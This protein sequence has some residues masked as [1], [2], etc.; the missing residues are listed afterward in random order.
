M[1]CSIEELKDID[2]L[3]VDELQVSLLIHEQK[4]TEKKGEEQAFQVEY[5][6]RNARGRGRWNPQ[7][8][9]DWSRG[10]G[11]GRPYVNRSVINCF[12]C[13]KHGHYQFK[14]NSLEKEVNYAEFDNEEELLLMAHVDMSESE[15][16]VLWFLDSGCSNHMT[17]DKSWFVELDEGF[18]HYV[19]LGNDSRMVV[20]GK[21]K[22]RI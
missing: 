15:G 4:V 14:C 8:G 18:K 16:E 10:R 1:V 19:R 9:S 3:T 22:I 11:R 17:R 21:G 2:H 6:P 5:E 13:G 7:R 20:Q 12:R